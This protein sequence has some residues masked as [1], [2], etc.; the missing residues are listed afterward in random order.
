[1]VTVKHVYGPVPSRRLDVKNYM[2]LAALAEK[3]GLVALK[4]KMEEQAA[5]E[6]GH[7]EEMQ[8][9]LG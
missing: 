6:D 9:L 1:M 7:R 4:M 8:R 3:E 2:R 5:D